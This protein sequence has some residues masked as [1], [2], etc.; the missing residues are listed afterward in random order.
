MSSSRLSICIAGSKRSLTAAGGASSQIGKIDGTSRSHSSMSSVSLHSF[1]STLAQHSVSNIKPYHIRHNIACSLGGAAARRQQCGTYLTRSNITALYIQRRCGGSALWL[2]GKR[3]TGWV[4]SWHHKTCAATCLV[5]SGRET[6]MVL[7][8]SAALRA[9]RRAATTTTLRMVSTVC[10]WWWQRAPLPHTHTLSP[11]PLSLS[12]SMRAHSIIHR[13]TARR[14][15]SVHCKS[16]EK[17]MVFSFFMPAKKSYN[18]MII[19]IAM[20]Q[21]RIF[22]YAWLDFPQAFLARTIIHLMCC[23]TW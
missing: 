10:S 13:T 9:P 15:S 8:R 2:V 16:T 4:F 21:S 22:R 17:L 1:K 11:D 6:C 23:D 5:W 19:K 3:P 18:S 12:L 7:M 14:I 20:L